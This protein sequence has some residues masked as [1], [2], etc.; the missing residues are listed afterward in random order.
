MK[1]F[2]EFHAAPCQDFPVRFTVGEEFLAEIEF[3]SFLFLIPRVER[4]HLLWFHGG[5]GIEEG[6][7]PG[8]LVFG[9]C[10][11]V[12]SKNIKKLYCFIM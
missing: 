5:G 6:V 4:L 8:S 12:E 11:G 2:L 7:G 1:Q 10:T 3:L 9:V